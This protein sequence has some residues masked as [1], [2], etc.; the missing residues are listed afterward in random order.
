MS[1]L[2]AARPR[3]EGE[4]GGRAPAAGPL[5]FPVAPGV[6][7]SRVGR[8]PGV[9]AGS[10][11][12]EPPSASQPDPTLS[13]QS[14]L[15]PPPSAGWLASPT[16]QG[17]ALAPQFRATLGDTPST[18][19]RLV[20]KP[21]PRHH[22]QKAES[23]CHVRAVGC[24]RIGEGLRVGRGPRRPE[25]LR[26]QGHIGAKRPPPPLPGPLLSELTGSGC[27]GGGGWSRTPETRTGGLVGK[28]QGGLASFHM[29][30]LAWTQHQE[31]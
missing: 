1:P 16:H 2:R 17:S 11:R 9:P 25:C 13:L 27:R 5:D 29:G 18:S 15:A 28:F 14:H 26:P 21:V 31:S 8:S 30:P 23:P 10:V 22:A 12:G 3:R 4:E 24:G 20:F 19:P 6:G 7:G